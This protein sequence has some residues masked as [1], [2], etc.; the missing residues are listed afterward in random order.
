MHSRV[1]KTGT[2]SQENLDQAGAEAS[3]EEEAAGEE[4]GWVRL[5][6]SF[7]FEVSRYP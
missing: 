6:P 1:S 3:R 5:A 4:G 2:V 7:F